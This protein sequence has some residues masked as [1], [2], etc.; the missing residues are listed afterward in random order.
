MCRLVSAKH[1]AAAVVQARE[2]QGSW[3]LDVKWPT[4]DDIACEVAFE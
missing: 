1:W 2:V 3:L 4:T